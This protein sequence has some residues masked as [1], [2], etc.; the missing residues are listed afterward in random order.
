MCNDILR[1]LR[2]AVRRKRPEKCR[3]NSWFLLHDNAPAHRSVLV[4]DF[5]AK[6]NVTTPEDPPYSPDLVPADFYLFP[7]LK[8]A[9]KGWRFCDASDTIKSETEE[10]ERLSQNSFQGCFSTRIQSLAEVYSRTRGLVWRKCRLNDCNVLYLS[11]IKWFREY[12][13]GTTYIN[14]AYNVTE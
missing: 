5:L 9:L 3:N 12:F 2:E 1:R 10:L 13:E 6:N 11:E 8:S 4:K 7:R 14:L